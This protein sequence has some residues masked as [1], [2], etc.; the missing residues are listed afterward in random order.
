[1]TD[2]AEKIIEVKKSFE[3]VSKKIAVLDQVLSEE[4]SAIVA[5]AFSAGRDLT[6]AEQ[7]R[8]RQIA[9]TRGE[10]AVALQALALDTI[11]KL[12]NSAIVESIKADILAV[13]HQ[14]SDDLKKLKDL[15]LHVAEAEAVAKGLANVITSLASLI[16]VI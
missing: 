8:L 1:M 11:A 10:L 2:K 4:R 16:A 12:E 3:A 15:V 9:A 13:N 5:K 7:A 6:V 14:L